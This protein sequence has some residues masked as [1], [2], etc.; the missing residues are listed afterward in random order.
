M[1][2][3]LLYTHDVDRKE[4]LA[5]IYLFSAR[6][7]PRNKSHAC[8]QEIHALESTHGFPKHSVLS[9]GGNFG[10]STVSETPKRC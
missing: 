3:C 10:G 2:F 8:S 1:S 4:L 7:I 9:L 5:D 6:V